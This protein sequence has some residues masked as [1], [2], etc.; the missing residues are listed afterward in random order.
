[1]SRRLYLPLFLLALLLCSTATPASAGVLGF[2]EW[3]LTA[4]GNKSMDADNGD[5]YEAGMF[6][7]V[8]MPLMKRKDLRLDFRVEGQFGVFWDYDTGV[9]VAIVPALRLYFTCSDAFQPYA[10]A[11]VGP[12]YNTLDIDELGLGFNFLSFGGLGLRFPLGEAMSLDVGYRWRHISNA[13]LDD[14]NQGVSS[15]QLQVGLAWAF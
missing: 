4:F 15:N 3:G 12:S 8:A 1:L 10:E 14:Q 7:H 9:D 13:G 5:L 11:G 6:A 2:N